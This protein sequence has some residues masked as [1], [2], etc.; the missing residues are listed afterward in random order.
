MAT[1]LAHHEEIEL[2]AD[3]EHALAAVG[4][5]PPEVLRPLLEGARARGMADAL[6]LIGVPA[7]LI[8]AAGAVLHVGAGA[9]SRMGNSVAIASRHLVGADA[10]SNRAL[11]DL[12]AAALAGEAKALELKVPAA[13]E[14]LSLRAIPMPRNWDNPYQLMKALIV[15]GDAPKPIDETASGD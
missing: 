1:P 4:D 2:V 15:F 6:E 12:V 14:G 11:Q 9:A 7:V 5:L 8:D 13:A 3:G 10:A